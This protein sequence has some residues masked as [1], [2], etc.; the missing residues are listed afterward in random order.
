MLRRLVTVLLIASAA[1]WL[2]GAAGPAGA[3]G[4]QSQRPAAAQL[5]GR[6]VA[7]A[8]PA[9]TG[10]SAVGAFHPGGPIR[11]KPEFA[12][13]TEPRR[14]LDP[15]RILVTSSSNFGAP[16]AIPD[17][18][19]GSVLSLDVAG[20]DILSVP[21]DFARAGGQA[22]VLDGRVQLFTAQSPA[23]VNGLN[24]PEAVTASLPP[25]SQPLAISIN[26]AFGRP[27]F[28]NAPNGWRGVGTESIADPNGL[29][30]A[31]APSKQAGGVFAGDQTGR[32]P[33]ILTPGAL[34]SAAIG[35]ALLG[36]SPDGGGRAVF[37]VVNADGS[38]VQAHSERGVDGLAPPGTMHP[39]TQGSSGSE[40]AAT[41]AGVV[42][43][44]VPN[45]IL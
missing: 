15:T 4:P 24:N 22:A 45:P 27:W 11:D 8:I 35:T 39:L 30:L 37:V 23:F 44:W 34:T 12:A 16:L 2:P 36:A 13:F 31:G 7:T 29:P 32:Q 20:P 40:P 6:I 10:I 9:A 43:N 25:V 18:P 5:Q 1:A 17:Q 19:A 26:N 28:A 21:P 38:L 14:I 42:F 3:A 41:H 33:Q